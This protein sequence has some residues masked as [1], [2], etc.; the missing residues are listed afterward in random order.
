MLRAA[1]PRGLAVIEDIDFAGY[2][3]HPPS[4]G[5][6]AYVRL[7]REAA[8]RQGADADIVVFDPATISDRSTFQNP[9]EPSVGVRYLVVGGTV[10][11]DE[12]KIV[13]DVFPG[14]ALLG[15]GKR[16]AMHD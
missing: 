14:R 15:P 7:Y 2:F 9:M 4:S 8:R 10:V 6:D 5:F 16:T 3:C 12:G 1:R 13:P 11:V